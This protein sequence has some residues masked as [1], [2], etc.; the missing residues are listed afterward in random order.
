LLILIT[1]IMLQI[2][3]VWYSFFSSRSAIQLDL[4]LQLGSMVL[5][6]ATIPSVKLLHLLTV[7]QIFPTNFRARGLNLAASGGSIGSIIAS[8]IWPVGMDRIGSKTYFVFM[9]VN[10]VSIIVRDPH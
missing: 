10:L 8:Q 5:R 3:H 1:S 9:C 4:D 2:I 7:L 6:Y